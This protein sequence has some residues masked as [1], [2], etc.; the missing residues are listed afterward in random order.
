MGLKDMFGW[1]SPKDQYGDA[2][3]LA[4]GVTTPITSTSLASLPYPYPNAAQNAAHNGYSGYQ[5]IAN[6]AAQAQQPSILQIQAYQQAY[7]QGQAKVQESPKVNL[8]EGAW[9][10][11]I[12][13]L[14]DLWVV[15]FGSKW[16]AHE[17]IAADEFYRIAS[18]RLEKTGKM[19]MHYLQ[20]RHMPVY[21]VVE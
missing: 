14:V 17:E 15:K 21:R 11:P 1:T 7:Q 16:V 20:D 4:Q 12:S 3:G 6:S 10:V 13:Q 5:N 8:N 19:E 2:L 18:L 9:T